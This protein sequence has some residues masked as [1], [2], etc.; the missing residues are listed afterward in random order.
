MLRRRTLSFL[1]ILTTAAALAIGSG[2]AGASGGSRGAT[3]PAPNFG[4][5]RV[6][7]LQFT[8]PV[9]VG[10]APDGTNTLYVVEQGG[11]IWKV[12]GTTRTR[13]VDLH[14]LVTAGGGEQGLLSMAF[15]TDFRTSGRFFV[16]FSTPAGTAGQVRSYLVRGGRVVSGSGKV[17][18]TVPLAPPTETNHNGGNL[19]V[20][21][22]G[23]LFLSVGDGGGGG[24]PSGNS[25]RLDRLMGKILRIVPK[26]G[27]GYVVPRSNPYYRRAGARKEVWALGLRNPWRFSIDGATGNMWIGDVGQGEF[28]EIDLIKA[29][30][31]A[32]P[33]FGWRRM[34]GNTVYAAGTRLTPGTPYV[35]PRIVYSHANG[36]CSVTGGVVYRGP[37]ESLRGWYLYADFCD[38]EITAYQASSSRSVA[39]VATGGIVHFGAGARGEVYVVSNAGGIYRITAS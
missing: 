24:D 19:W 26:A 11:V 23:T 35:K 17:I 30:S 8:A 7:N 10:G 36:G 32:G 25:Q 37:I 20:Q 9:W 29:S 12:N 18:I 4:L 5:T 3:P 21:A 15:A 16:Y 34:E 39:R 28:E 14:R 33:N 13:F 31:V 2:Q 6:G 38:N 1:I 22:N 27:G